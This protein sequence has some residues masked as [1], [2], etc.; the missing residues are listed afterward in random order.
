MKDNITAED[1][2]KYLDEQHGEAWSNDY[3]DLSNRMQEYAEIYYKQKIKEQTDFEDELKNLSKTLD[4][5]KWKAKRIDSANKGLYTLDEV[6]ELLSTQRGNCY[7]AILNK[8]GDNELATLCSR[9]P[10]PGGGELNQASWRN[11]FK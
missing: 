7:V 6:A 1:F 10:E 2:C 5:L 11:K 9:A 4:D 3:E 8:T